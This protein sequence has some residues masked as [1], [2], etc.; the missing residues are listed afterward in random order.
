MK[1]TSLLHS[2]ILVFKNFFSQAY[3]GHLMPG[4]MGESEYEYRVVVSG[5]KE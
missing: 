2:L 4:R 5:R 3:R 1:D